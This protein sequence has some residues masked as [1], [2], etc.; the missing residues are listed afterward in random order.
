MGVDF[1]DHEKWIL[2]L[3][4][5]N[6]DVL[7]MTPQI[8]YNA[9]THAFMDISSVGLIVM[10]EVHHCRKRH[11]YNTIM[12]EFY[13][14]LSPTSRPKILGLTASPI[15]N[16]KNPLGG[17]QTLE[18]NTQSKIV[19]VKT[20][21]D[22]L[23]RYA[24]EPVEEVVFYRPSVGL[25]PTRLFADIMA[26]GLVKVGKE[27][28]DKVGTKAIVALE[29][30]GEVAMDRYLLESLLSP[31][32]DIIMLHE[33]TSSDGRLDGRLLQLRDLL[34]ARTVMEDEPIFSRKILS[35]VESLQYHRSQNLEKSDYQAI[36]FVQQRHIASNLSFLLHKIPDIPWIS[37]RTLVGHGSHGR[38]ALEEQ[39]FKRQ[40][41]IVADFR[42]GVFNVLISTSVGE[43]GLDF[44]ACDL[45]IRFDAIHTMVGYVQ[46][47]GR[48]RMKKSKYVVMVDETNQDGYA[49]YLAYSNA[50][51]RM[52]EVYK[53]QRGPIPEYDEEEND[54]NESD[55]RSRERY[56][57]QTTGAI[58]TY[59]EAVSLV[60]QT[61]AL[62]PSAEGADASRPSYQISNEFG[63]FSARITMP[64]VCSLPRDKLSAWGGSRSNKSEAKRAVAF[65]ICKVLHEHG[66]LNDY[67]LPNREKVPVDMDSVENEPDL[68]HELIIQVPAT[69][70]DESMREPSATLSLH[71]VK[72][73]GVAQVGIICTRSIPPVGLFKLWRGH[74]E[75]ETAVTVQVEEPT[76][77]DFNSV[78][79]G[80]SVGFQ[81][82]DSSTRYIITTMLRPQWTKDI[83]L[84]IFFAILDG[85]GNID[86]LSMAA[87]CSASANGAFAAGNILLDS[88]GRQFIVEC[89]RTDINPMSQ[90]ETVDGKCRESDHESYLDYA[91]KHLRKTR[92]SWEAE[93]APDTPMLQVRR[94]PNRRHNLQ[95]MY[96]LQKERP[97]EKP[98][99]FESH[100]S[101]L[102]SSL[103]NKLSITAST[104]EDVMV[105]ARVDYVVQY[106]DRFPTLSSFRPSC[107]AL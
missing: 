5:K 59:G 56:V 103:C 20:N 85:Q 53:H 11:P 19:A 98:N 76:T 16:L 21:A 14:P 33:M 88:L 91:N 44:P 95:P 4:L 78:Q 93:I 45:V 87:M 17:L 29:V 101:V 47:R 7:V 66:L 64:S 58:L 61:C 24:N 41:A 54:I 96:V 22:E 99:G 60:N 72:I 90:R 34:E 73:D 13:H 100:P 89:L 69:W 15:W 31:T 107:G 104:R 55:R 39:D 86:W 80:R 1:W 62:L 9:L 83:D 75:A 12:E 40:E 27:H 102:I 77:L 2:E 79:E 50:E 42:A 82:L 46:S 74:N 71:R 67:L 105:S 94:L 8:F 65:Y 18:M 52:T 68:E 30:L 26:L 63:T 28:L 35:L 37:A 38:I 6:T 23:E 51:G 48:A 36:I 43:E 10:D 92:A 32:K 97:I 70:G 84:S 81:I 25:Q 57:V 49:K 3:D 106:I